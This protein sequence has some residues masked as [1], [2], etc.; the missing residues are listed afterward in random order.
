MDLISWYRALADSRK[1]RDRESGLEHEQAIIRLILGAAATGYFFLPHVASAIADHKLL[2]S[3]HILGLGF[4]AASSCLFLWVH[5]DPRHLPLRRLVGIALDTATT[6]AALYLGEEQGA[7]LV[8]I[9]LWVIVGN[10]FR[11]GVPYLV[12]SSLLSAFGFSLCAFLSDY[13]PHHPSFVSS[14]VVL[15]LVVPVYMGI[16]LKKLNSAVHQAEEAN[17]AKSHFL[18]NMSHELRTPLNGVIGMADL[19]VQTRLDKE[20][21]ELAS[22]INT[23][24]QILSG[25]IENVLDLSKI[26]AGRVNV[27]E[28][29]FDLHRL[30]TDTARM[31]QHRAQ[32]KGLA[33][34]THIDPEAPFALRGDS[35]HIRQVL[36]NLIGNAI[37][38][39]HAG[40]IDVRVSAM[41]TA[42]SVGARFRFEI[43]D[44]GIGIDSDHHERIFESF[45][46]GHRDIGKRFGGTGL[47]T[48]ISRRLVELMGGTIGLASEPGRGTCFWFELPLRV[49][50]GREISS[51]LSGGNTEVLILARPD[52]LAQLRPLLGLWNIGFDQLQ[53]PAQVSSLLT[54]SAS[55]RAAGYSLLLVDDQ[56]T[57]PFALAKSIRSSPALSRLALILLASES[58]LDTKQRAASAGY[59]SVVHPPLDK[60]LLFN[61]IH[62]A[63]AGHEMPENV[64]TL[65]EEYHRIKEP[66]TALE[67][68][69][70]EDNEINRKVLERMLTKAHHHCHLAADGESALDAIM[71]LELRDQLDLLILDLNMP[72]RNGIEVLQ[73]YQ[74][75]AEGSAAPV[76]ILTADATPETAAACRAAGADAVLT[77]P[78]SSRKL[79]DA[80]ASLCAGELRRS[81]AKEMRKPGAV[82]NESPGQPRLLDEQQLRHLCSLAT[83]QEFFGQMR[84]ALKRDGRRILS[85]LQATVQESDYPGFRDG[86]HALRGVSGEFGA[87][88]L[89]SICDNARQLKPF[90]IGGPKGATMVQQLSEIFEKTITALHAFAPVRTG[91]SKGMET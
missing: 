32:E 49:M 16:L 8:A 58:R 6:S 17:R 18:A 34:H 11:F 36:I 81:S 39:T 33:L 24:A 3:I 83:D 87:D 91:E 27:E 73:A 40:H 15:L 44:T 13:W 30:I 35:L 66:E 51:P 85:E 72:G 62:A 23:S 20:Q 22:T 55:A 68:L 21:Q 76:I 57:D 48:T 75:L 29:D 74:Y 63:H 50:A 71:E 5:L 56:L 42:G 38:F 59:S 25:L 88:L 79:F 80:L 70:A 4:L 10:G 52:L 77:K 12:A 9:Y 54:E 86:L 19:L 14:I 69:V 41:P 84:E 67:I 61:A 26:E 65:I 47:G 82:S 60:R 28:T 31:F 45:H 2:S 78:I 43:E 53:S 37:K 64:V 89:L 90:E 1:P 46:Q 7:F